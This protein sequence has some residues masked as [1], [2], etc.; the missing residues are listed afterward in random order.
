MTGNRP[1]GIVPALALPAHA[2]LEIM[3]PTKLQPIVTAIPAGEQFHD[4]G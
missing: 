3:F 1:N 4:N 2:R